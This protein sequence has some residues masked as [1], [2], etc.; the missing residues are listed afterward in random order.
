MYF[1]Q[2]VLITLHEENFSK[3]LEKYRLPL[4]YKNNDPLDTEYSSKGS[5]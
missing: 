3:L 4:G 1:P 2:S 5:A